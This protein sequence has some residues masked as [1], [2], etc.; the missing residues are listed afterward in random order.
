M[1]MFLDIHD[2]LSK[3]GK[4]VAEYDNPSSKKK[5]GTSWHDE[6]VRKATESFTKPQPVNKPAAKKVQTQQSRSG[7]TKTAQRK[8]VQKRVPR[9]K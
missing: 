3:W 2:K 6:M 5:P 7:G 4:R 1:Q 8:P 9:K